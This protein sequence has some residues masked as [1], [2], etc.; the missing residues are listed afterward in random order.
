MQKFFGQPRLIT[1]ILPHRKVSWLELFYDLIFAV[2]L[3]RLTDPLVE[4]FTPARFAYAT[5]V[6]AWFFWSWHDTSGYFDN[7]GNA[8]LINLFLISAQVVITGV[9]ALYIPVAVGG[10]FRPLFPW[11]V[12]M[13]ALLSLIWRLIAAI[14]VHHAPASRIWSR[15]YAGVAVLLIV[16][17]FAP[18][19]WLPWIALLAAVLN[20][21]VIL[22][23]RGALCREYRALGQ[24]FVLKD[25]LLERY[26]LMTM[27]AL[28][29]IIAGLFTY[30]GDEPSPTRLAGFG[31]SIIL[32][33]L[34]GGVYYLML[35]A[36]TI[37]MQSSLQV[38]AIRWL[39]LVVVYLLMVMAVMVDLALAHPVTVWRVALVCVLVATFLVMWIIR[40]VTG[41]S[42]NPRLLVPAMVGL[43]VL[44]GVAFVGSALVT[45][46][47][48][49]VAIAAAMVPAVARVQA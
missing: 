24:P 20:F 49:D 32:V 3:A 11:M 27:I 36:V 22:V 41:N 30:A 5:I 48:M 31:A 14:D 38:M 34:V 42:E 21:G 40:Y 16:G 46:I 45:V 10:D 6:F 7:H 47:A 18:A 29:E 37:E 2:V 17:W 15:A 35:G 8:T 33:A 25:S 9:A 12:V 13:S 43:L 23:G 1:N 28:G 19:T 4:D 26:G 39:F 44:V